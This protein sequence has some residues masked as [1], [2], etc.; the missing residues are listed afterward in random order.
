VQ[1]TLT[2]TPA[3][4]LRYALGSVWTVTGD[5]AI[6]KYTVSGQRAA[7]LIGS[8]VIDAKFVGGDMYVLTKSAVEQVNPSSGAPTHSYSISQPVSFDVSAG[9]A[10]ILQ[11]TATAAVVDAVDVATGHTQTHKLPKP[12]GDNEL[13]DS[14]A[15]DGSGNVWVIDAKALLKMSA[16][17]L[18]VEG[19]YALPNGE[20]DLRPTSA[21][22][23]V[24]TQNPQGGVVRLLPGATAVSPCWAGGDALQMIPDGA[25]LWLSAAAGLTKLSQQSCAV[26][27]QA[28]PVDGGA[29]GVAVLPTQVWVSFP[30]EIQVQVVAR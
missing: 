4:I 20:T 5:G 17:S 25:D 22:V 2:A 3:G 15:A 1:R 27:A 12:V 18:A 24:A 14:I 11:S 21:G 19:Q 10:F 8:G 9:V 13:T 16:A 26:L 28:T 29:T 23:F 30:D 6:D 7:R